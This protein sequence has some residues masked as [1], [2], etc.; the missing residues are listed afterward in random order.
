MRPTHEPN[1][2]AAGADLVTRFM[3][4]NDELSRKS[5]PQAGQ[6]SLFIGQMHSGEIFNQYPQECWLE[7]TRRW[8][9][10]TDPAGVESGFHEL[11][12]PFSADWKVEAKIDYNLIPHAFR[13]HLA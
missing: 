6:E 12:K 2:V 13:L 10:E 9:P 4:L 7:G 11:V 1:V 3:K 5:D 8:L